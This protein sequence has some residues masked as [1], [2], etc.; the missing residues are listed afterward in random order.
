ME[1]MTGGGCWH[2]SGARGPSMGHQQSVNIT[3]AHQELNADL[4]M[5]LRVLYCILILFTKGKA[6][7][8]SV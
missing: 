2:E 5:L 1:A 7:L 4:S 8:M 3:P 6:S